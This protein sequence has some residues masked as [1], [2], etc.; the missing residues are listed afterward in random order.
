MKL[1][2]LTEQYQA[3][4]AMMDDP[5]I[6]PQAVQDTLEGLDGDVTEKA[7]GIACIIKDCLSDEAALKAEAKA[8]TD[9]AK[10]KKGKAAWLTDYLFRQMQAMGKTEIETAR[11]LLKIKKNPAAVKI[12]DENAFIAWATSDHEEFLRQ[13]APEI[14]RAAVKDALR[15]GQEIPG[16]ALEQAEKLTIK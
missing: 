1:Y 7:D 8:L 4:S 6:D 3:L 15:A 5:E 9:R 2:E 12:E 14:N 10:A 13:A 11:N 16:A